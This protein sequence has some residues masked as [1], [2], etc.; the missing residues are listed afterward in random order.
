MT[1][2]SRKPCFLTL[3]FAAACGFF[4]SMNVAHA[5]G[6]NIIAK[7][8]LIVDLDADKDV[9]QD[10]GQIASWKNQVD[11]KASLFKATRPDGH[12]TL[13]PKVESING[14]AS[15]IFK[16]QELLNDDE[17]A[18]DRLI[19]GSGYTWFAV[20]SPGHQIT[21]LKDVCSFFGDLKNGPFYEG[22]WAGFTDDD[23]IWA[24]SRNGR[25]QQTG[26]PD[27]PKVLGTSQL[28]EGVFYV[29]AGRMAAGTGDVKIELFVND[30]KPAAAGIYPVN[31]AANSSKMAI[32]QERDATNHPGRESYIGEMARI[33]FWERPLNDA[34]MQGTMNALKAYYGIK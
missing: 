29:A 26:N 33:M 14:H 7:S 8:G 11:W 32:G 10:N 15:I 27:N 5:Q 25:S 23:V 31:P 4:L 18:F 17:D 28:K 20:V 13:R 24:G 1:Y 34:E 19:T 22:F 6:G 12:P 30:P 3:V 2:D 9:V 21:M 16:K